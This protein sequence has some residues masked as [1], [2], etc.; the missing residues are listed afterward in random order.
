VT[1][2]HVLGIC[3][4]FIFAA[5]SLR[6]GYSVISGEAQF[7]FTIKFLLTINKLLLIILDTYKQWELIFKKHIFLAL[8]QK[9]NGINPEPR[10]C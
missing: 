2:Y 3:C 1:L 9:M 4:Y 10:A 6:Q 7:F 5:A 8:L